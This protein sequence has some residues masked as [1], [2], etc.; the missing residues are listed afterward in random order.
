MWWFF[1]L[2]WNGDRERAE[3]RG[4][5][6]GLWLGCSP[7]GRLEPAEEGSGC[8]RA[9]FPLRLRQLLETLPFFLKTL[10]EEDQLKQ[11]K[12]SIKPYGVILRPKGKY[13]DGK[14]R[15]SAVGTPP[16][17]CSRRASLCSPSH[18]LTALSPPPSCCP[19]AWP[20]CLVRQMNCPVCALP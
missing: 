20:H 18:P 8:G 9:C 4:G 17:V 11:Q 2:G 6:G 3:A 10:R 7:G 15:W 13:L 16:T 14:G 12:T 5:G 1:C 19:G